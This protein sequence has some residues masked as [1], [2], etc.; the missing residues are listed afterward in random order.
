MNSKYNEFI[1]YDNKILE[2]LREIMESDRDEAF[3]LLYQ[4]EPIKPKGKPYRCICHSLDIRFG[5]VI[6]LE[7]SFRES[8][9]TIIT[10]SPYNNKFKKTYKNYGEFLKEW[11]EVG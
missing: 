1:I 8:G 11:E 10:K 9:R 6:D 5:Q 3:K 4:Q 7:L 2:T